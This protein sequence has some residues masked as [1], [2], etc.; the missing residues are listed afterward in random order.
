MHPWNLY[1]LQ[2]YQSTYI[3]T[4]GSYISLLSLRNMKICKF[5][6]LPKSCKFHLLPEF[7]FKRKHL[8]LEGVTK[9]LPQILQYLMK[10]EKQS[11]RILSLWQIK[12][13][14]NRLERQF[15]WCWDERGRHFSGNCKVIPSRVKRNCKNGTPC[16]HVTITGKQGGEARRSRETCLYC[17]TGGRHRKEGGESWQTPDAN[18]TTHNIKSWEQHEIQCLKAEVFNLLTAGTL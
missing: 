11:L 12:V 17:Y 6:L 16:A 13:W 10:T 5:Y 3:T 4:E 8:S 9:H 2:T 1:T 18:K 7:S 15:E 14:K